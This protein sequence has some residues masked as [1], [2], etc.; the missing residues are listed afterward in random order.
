MAMGCDSKR[1]HLLTLIPSESALAAAAFRLLLAKIEND[2]DPDKILKRILDA[3]AG[4]IEKGDYDVGG[5]GELLVRILC[6][7]FHI[8]C[9]N[10]C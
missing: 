1:T 7:P 5:D 6:I 4:E 2:Q 3:V 10:T 8:Y 9:I